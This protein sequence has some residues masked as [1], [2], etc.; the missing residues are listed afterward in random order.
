M[1]SGTDYA[2]EINSDGNVF[3]IEKS[4][5]MQRTSFSSVAEAMNELE[6]AIR[7][8]TGLSARWSHVNQSLAN[9][10]ISKKEIPKKKGF[11]SWFKRR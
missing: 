6:M 11:F 5:S 3:F 8:E 1:P 4:E 9:A 7:N 2:V 10:L